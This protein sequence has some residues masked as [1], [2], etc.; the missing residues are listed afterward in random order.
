MDKLSKYSTQKSGR[1]WGLIAL[2]ASTFVNLYLLKQL[3]KIILLFSLF[4]FGIG[5]KNC[6]TFD[7][8]C[9]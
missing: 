4:Y 5:I 9:K 2:L 3:Y 1:L 7:Y 8:L 6:N